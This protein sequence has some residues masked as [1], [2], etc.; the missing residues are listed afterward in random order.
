MRRLLLILLLGGVAFPAAAQL[1][2]PSPVVGPQ[3]PCGPQPIYPPP[4]EIGGKP[5]VATWRQADLARLG[6]Q[7][8][9]CLE[10]RGDSR[11][12]A[13]LAARFR[14]PR[15]LDELAAPLAAVSNYPAIKFWA[16]THR[17]WRPLALAAWSVEGPE[18]RARQPDPSV[19]ALQPGRTFYYAEDAEM[20][21]RA[22]YRLRVLEH[23]SD[24]LV[25]ESENVSPIRVAFITLFEPGALQVA[26]FLQ[27]LDGDVWELYE[28]TRA[29]AGSSSMVSAY[30]SAYLNRLEAVRRLIVGDPTDRDPPIAPW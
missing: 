21:G 10:W 25:I 19:A 8:Q 17:D 24:R 7:P 15:P 23:G 29:T 16:V 13:A 6:W 1:P 26:T 12:I 28:I 18:A 22:V 9:A 20:A 14:S 2:G 11:L 3:P 30:Q 4:G 5:L 27:R